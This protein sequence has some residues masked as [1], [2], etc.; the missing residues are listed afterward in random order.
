V[1]VAHFSVLPVSVRRALVILAQR[2][3]RRKSAYWES[4]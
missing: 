1:G 2:Q 3:E 4:N